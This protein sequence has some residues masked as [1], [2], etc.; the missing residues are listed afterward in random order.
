MKLHIMTLHPKTPQNMY[1]YTYR[2]VAIKGL[3]W[4][5]YVQFY[6]SQ[7]SHTIMWSQPS[8]AATD[9]SNFI[10]SIFLNPPSANYYIAVPLNQNNDYKLILLKKDGSHSSTNMPDLKSAVVGKNGSGQQLS[11]EY[12]TE[13][14]HREL[15]VQPIILAYERLIL[16]CSKSLD[17]I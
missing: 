15:L 12:Y 8:P 6:S 4:Y 1:A 10:P 7:E 17:D 9:Q 13:M 14:H 3:E 11:S 2:I 16:S 5:V